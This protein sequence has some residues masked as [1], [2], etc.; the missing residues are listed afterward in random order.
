MPKQ[1]RSKAAAKA[2]TSAQASANS[3]APPSPEPNTFPDRRGTLLAGGLIVLAALAAYHN[4]F[5][6]PF[7]MD[8]Y[9]AITGNPT[10]KHL[11]SALSPPPSSTVGGR[12][13]INL[14]FAVNYALGGMNPWGYHALNLL[15]HTLA[16]LTLFGIVRRSLLECG[17]GALTRHLSR[18]RDEGTPPTVLA[19]A[20]SVIWIGH[21]VQTEAVT[22]IT[23][24]AEFLLGL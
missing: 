16:G 14:T 22:Y 9:P 13:V 5:S 20:V 18:S 10:I 21:P 19:L 4:S 17:R 7:I 6:G 23:Q 3:S 1:S 12:P 15:N 8:D 2:A 11:G 24:R